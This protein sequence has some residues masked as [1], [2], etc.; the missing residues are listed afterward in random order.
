MSL[1]YWHN[2]DLCSQ[3]DIKVPL[4]R[5]RAK[6]QSVEHLLPHPN[7]ALLNFSP[8]HFP[9]MLW[10]K[11]SPRCA[12]HVFSIWDEETRLKWSSNKARECSVFFSLEVYAW[13]YS[14]FMLLLTHLGW[15]RKQNPES[16]INQQSWLALTE[17]NHTKSVLRFALLGWGWT[18]QQASRYLEMVHVLNVTCCEVS[19][20]RYIWGSTRLPGL[21]NISPRIMFLLKK[22]IPYLN[23]V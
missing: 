11:W 20:H 15:C 17:Q 5:A 6:A 2:S 12:F 7:S 23:L 16:P 19:V 13:P 18:V 22:R 10:R 14:C 4:G 8:F 1:V 9:Q 21:M 3:G